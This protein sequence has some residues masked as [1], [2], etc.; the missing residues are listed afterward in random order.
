VKLIE[1]RFRGLFVS[2][3]A[4]FTL[5]GTSMTI[6]GATLPK[7]LAN[8]HWDYLT[9]GIVIGAGAVAYFVSTFVAGYLVK[10]WGPKPTILVALTLIVA[11]LAFFAT[12]PDP[13]AN[14]LLS[15]LIGLGQGGVEVGVNSTILR[16]DVRNTGRPMNLLH[17]AFAVGAIAG[18]L[19][20]SLLLQSGLDWAAVYRGMAAIFALLAALMAFAALPSIQQKADEHDETP[21]RLSAN[22]AYWLS[23]FALF[24]YLGVELGVSNWVAEYFVVVFAYSPD[25]SAMLVSLFW[26]GLLAGRFGVPLLYKDSHPDAVLV[27]LS[28]LAT[29]SI[30]LL[31]A[32]G[33]AAPTAIA[34]D[35]ARGLLF[36]AGLGCSIYYPGVMTLVGKCFPRAQSQAI[37]FAATGGGIGS[38]IFPFLMSSIAQNWGIRAGFAAYSVFAAGMTVVGVWLAVVASKGKNVRALSLSTLR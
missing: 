7:I 9:A 26:L 24:L 16:M 19:A 25:A 17:G 38:F 13:A 21:E 34:A 4:L 18:P 14:T 29:A 23:F 31:M 1:P 22:P 10:H 36:L 32:L 5:F 2:L 12:T 11:G 35:I 20:V 37:G 8:F 3:F 27:G 30:A 6:I 28:A 15:A 33:C